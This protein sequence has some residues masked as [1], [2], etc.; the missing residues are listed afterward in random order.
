[1]TGRPLD[2]ALGRTGGRGPHFL[3][4]FL[5]VFKLLALFWSEIAHVMHLIFLLVKLQVKCNQNHVC[6]PLAQKYDHIYK[7]CVF[8]EVALGDNHSSD[9]RAPL[10]DHQIQKV[11]NKVNKCF[12]PNLVDAQKRCMHL[13][14]CACPVGRGSRTTFTSFSKNLNYERWHH[15]QLPAHELCNHR[16]NVPKRANNIF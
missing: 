15:E 8:A 6:G 5:N 14:A 16:E 4:Y 2:P 9:T 11:N 13:H 7:T 1:M 12:L 10:T 3:M